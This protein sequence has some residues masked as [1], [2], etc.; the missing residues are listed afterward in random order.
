[1]QWKRIERSERDHDRTNFYR[2]K[3]PR[4]GKSGEKLQ[5]TAPTPFR[6]VKFERV[7]T[8]RERVH[9]FSLRC[10]IVCFFSNF[11]LLLSLLSYKLIFI[12]HI[13][14]LAESRISNLSLDRS[15]KSTENISI[16]SSA[17]KNV[18]LSFYLL[19]RSQIINEQPFL[20]ASTGN[21]SFVVSLWI[22]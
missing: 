21:S 18:F 9:H 11:I 20:S 10:D 15:I 16:Q 12:I 6:N 22:N 4:T 1:M 8:A 5:S 7:A 13:S 14:P 3:N 2:H 17:K 19:L